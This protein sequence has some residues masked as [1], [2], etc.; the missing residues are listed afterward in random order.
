MSCWQC[1]ALLSDAKRQRDC[2]EAVC[3]RR[4]AAPLFL[5][6]EGKTLSGFESMFAYLVTEKLPRF[7]CLL[8]ARCQQKQAARRESLVLL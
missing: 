2:P 1:Q 4:E 3:C 8:P 5:V 7:A 6:Q